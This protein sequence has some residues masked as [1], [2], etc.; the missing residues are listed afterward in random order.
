MQ[1]NMIVAA[2]LLLA[3]ILPMA[4]AADENIINL[5]AGWGH[6]KGALNLTNVTMVEAY[7]AFNISDADPE[8]LDESALYDAVGIIKR[9]RDYG[10]LVNYLICRD[11][12]V[13]CLA[14]NDSRVWHAK[15]YNNNSLGVRFVALNAT[16]A[17]RLSRQKGR[18][19]LPG[20]NDRQYEAL[21]RLVAEL[22]DGA[23]PNIVEVVGYD[24][25]KAAQNVTVPDSEID[26]QKANRHLERRG[27]EIRHF[28]RQTSSL[29]FKDFL[30][31]FCVA[32]E[33]ML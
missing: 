21:G 18:E 12:T 5:Y 23:Y 7:Y 20:P 27:L 28:F 16:I 3:G 11:G 30:F 6:E 10:V 26:W 25:L 22:K 29:I 19:I 24:E 1:A 31:K 15:G 33:A 2:M 4:V 8:E 9:Y 13:I 17:A 14:E 32:L